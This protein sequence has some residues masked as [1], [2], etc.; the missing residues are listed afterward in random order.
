MTYNWGYL[1]STTGGAAADGDSI[2]DRMLINTTDNSYGPDGSG[3]SS[4]EKAAVEASRL[5]DIFLKPYVT[6]PFT[7]FPLDAILQMICADFAA[8]IFKR[9]QYP[10]EQ[11]MK[12]SL[13]PDMINDVEGTGWFA[14]GLK[15]LQ[16]Y[17]KTVYALG[18][19][20]GNT[21][22]NPEIYAE[23]YK[24]GMITL[25]EFRTFES[26]PAA[27]I[28]RITN[29]K[30]VNNIL[31]IQSNTELLTRRI[32]ITKKQKS[33]AFISSD[34]NGGYQVDSEAY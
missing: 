23:L 11:G 10:S 17:I 31:N 14:V 32:Y 1:S 15:R 13:Q 24:N 5:M 29:N 2:K 27:A 34:G 33:F 28:N 18:V 22:N 16:D 3:T 8:S 19:A 30:T 12:P 20:M 21:V 6:V 9:R 4:L 25:K 26:N 7:S